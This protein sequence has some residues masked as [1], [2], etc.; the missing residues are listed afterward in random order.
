MK[1]KKVHELLAS[2]RPGMPTEQ[3]DHR[4]QASL[5]TMSESDA[6]TRSYARTMRVALALIIG[7]LLAVGGIA[8][9]PL[10]P[11]P[12]TLVWAEVEAALRNGLNEAQALHLRRRIFLTDSGAEYGDVVEYSEIWIVRPNLLREENWA[13]IAE[14]LVGNT[15]A[16]PRHFTR[17]INQE[18]EWR[19]DQTEQRWG[20]RPADTPILSYD[21]PVTPT[22][23]VDREVAFLWEKEFQFPPLAADE[24]GTLVGSR[25]TDEG[26]VSIYRFEGEEG[27]WTQ[28]TFRDSQLIEVSFGHDKD[29]LP[30]SIYGPID[31]APAIDMSMFDYTPEAGY[32]NGQLLGLE[33]LPYLIRPDLVKLHVDA[34]SVSFANLV[35]PKQET[36]DAMMASLRVFY[37]G[38]GNHHRTIVAV[39][40]SDYGPLQDDGTPLWIWNTT[41]TSSPLGGHYLGVEVAGVDESSQKQ[42]L[43]IVSALE[44]D[45]DAPVIFELITY[46]LDRGYCKVAYDANRDGVFDA[47]AMISEPDKDEWEAAHPE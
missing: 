44:Y 6:G 41:T 19:I 13:E 24:R 18:A 39:E 37:G 46:C 32:V 3:L 33:D 12:E 31:Y 25:E 20:K 17:I 21:P 27:H 14:H 36:V 11:A 4:I 15:W 23:L 16:P 7:V 10:G 1:A 9:L 29:N 34:S 38:A 47:W 30:R 5:S 43:K 2:A 45:G 28:C 26:P 22:E 42:R 8:L 35:K 40:G